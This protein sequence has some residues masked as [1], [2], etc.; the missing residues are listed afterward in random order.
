MIGVAMAV[1]SPDFLKSKLEPLGAGRSISTISSLVG[2]PILFTPT[3]AAAKRT[4]E[5][6]TA[7]IRNSNTRKAYALAIGEFAA[8][9][10]IHG[11]KDLGAIEPVHIAAYTEQ[12]Q[13]RLSAPSVK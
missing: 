6:F 9:C 7:N 12:L 4:L 5:F 8:W 2:L 10:D 11:L 3:P 13:A 1:A